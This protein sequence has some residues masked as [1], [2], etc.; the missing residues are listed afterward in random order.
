MLPILI[1]FKVI[2]HTLPYRGIILSMII[3]V[4]PV[5]VHYC[6]ATTLYL[7]CFPFLPTLLT[8]TV[9]DT[10]P[11]FRTL[12][13]FCPSYHV[14]CNVYPVIY[15]NFTLLHQ[16]YFLPIMYFEYFYS[17][18]ISSAPCNFHFIWWLALIPRTSFRSWWWIMN[19]S[20][21]RYILLL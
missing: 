17:L 4:S 12:L 11:Y 10:S 5:P 15:Q 7:N 6:T 1:S 13:L 3:L 18:L 14:A 16:H 9:L 21:R 19:E 8:L 20:K 2:D